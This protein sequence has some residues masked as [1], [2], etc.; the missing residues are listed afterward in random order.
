M[1]LPKRS[2]GSCLPDRDEAGFGSADVQVH[3]ASFRDGDAAEADKLALT[4][5]D[6][7]L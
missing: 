3:F 4:A 5:S 1:Q 7:F 2:I 6:Q